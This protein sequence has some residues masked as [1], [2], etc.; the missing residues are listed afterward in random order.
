MKIPAILTAAA[1][2]GFLAWTAGST[3]AQGD[4]EPF[5]ITVETCRVDQPERAGDWLCAPVRE[6]EAELVVIWV[7]GGSRSARYVFVKGETLPVG[8]KPVRFSVEGTPVPIVGD[9]AVDDAGQFKGRTFAPLEGGEY[10]ITFTA[11]DGRGEASVKVSAIELEEMEEKTVAAVKEA[12]E[13]AEK[14]VTAAEAKLDD[15]P[16]SPAKDTAKRKIA[17]AKAAVKEL[18]A[19]QSARTGLSGL[20]GAI[21]A[22]DVLAERAVGPL[23]TMA[24]RVVDLRRETARVR[25]LSSGMSAADVGCHQLA[26]VTELFKAVS[27]LLN[28]KKSVV[29]IAVGLAKDLVSDFAGNAAK[30][31]G[32]GPGLAFATGQIV[33]NAPELNRAS[34]LA[35]NAYGMMADAGAFLSDTAFGAYCEQFVGPVEATMEA[36]FTDPSPWWSYRFKITG[37]LLLYYPKSAKGKSIRLHGRLEGVAHSFETKENALSV[38]YPGLMSSAIQKKRHFPPIEIG[39]GA[40]QIATQGAAGGTSGYVEGSGAAL[41]L[42]NSF[43]IDVTGLLEENS[44]SLILGAAKSDFSAKHRVV[45]IALSPLALSYGIVPIWYELPFKDAHHVFLRASQGQSMRL[46][47][48]RTGATMTAEGR[49]AAKSG[50]GGS[51]GEYTATLKA[52]NP[53]C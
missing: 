22:E 13:A 27:A 39:A 21:R 1:L 33:K 5:P 50:S 2:V 26:F 15:I 48:K 11:P 17:A 37:R 47:L 9:L 19:S 8:G 46:P 34:A 42:P 45:T 35:G 29:D 18:A 28:I 32:A 16:A 31:K 49:F 3:Q 44:L 41:A 30:A 20:I 10:T 12:A 7:K 43:L 6:A 38:L 14:A 4:T 25:D 51:H 52:C 53:G 40:A 23:Q 36:R 24:D